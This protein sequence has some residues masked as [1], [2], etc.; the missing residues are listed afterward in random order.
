MAHA[1]RTPKGRNPVN[2]RWFEVIFSALLLAACASA[3]PVEDV[4]GAARNALAAAEAADA[5]ELAPLE[6]RFA[7][8][9]FAEAQTF[10][11]AGKN[12]EA[13]WRAEQAEVGAQLAEVKAEATDA[14]NQVRSMRDQISRL[15]QDI[16]AL[17]SADS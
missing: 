3:P 1:K 12:Q 14:R 9:K 8:E 11:R 16:D 2:I 10:A 6:M 7:R 4:L 13:G 5:D 15:M 17:T